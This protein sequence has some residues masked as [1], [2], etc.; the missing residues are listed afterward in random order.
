[1]ILSTLSIQKY[2]IIQFLGSAGFAFVLYVIYLQNEQI[3][4]LNNKIEN[5]STNIA[6]KEKDLNTL[7]S[8][9]PTEVNTLLITQYNETIKLYIL[10]AGGVVLCVAGVYMFSNLFQVFSLKKIIPVSFFTQ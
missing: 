3:K 4:L 1:M 7:M 5:L 10:I 8:K 2:S 6:E 9:L